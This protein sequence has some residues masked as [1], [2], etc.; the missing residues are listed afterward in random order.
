MHKLKTVK[1][2]FRKKLLALHCAYDLSHFTNYETSA[3]FLQKSYY[4]NLHWETVKINY[5]FLCWIVNLLH[6]QGSTTV[7]TSGHISGHYRCGHLAMTYTSLCSLLILGDN[8]SRVDKKSVLEGILLY[9][10]LLDFFVILFLIFFVT[11]EGVGALQTEEGSFNGSLYGTESDM[12][13][14][15]CA[16]AICY[17]LNDWSTIDREKMAEYIIKSM[18]LTNIVNKDL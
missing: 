5:I 4:S 15:F 12:R 16:A 10:F 3:N 17:I 2:I 8:L 18:V 11:W 1:I 7:N 9:E 13:F 14:T 6:I